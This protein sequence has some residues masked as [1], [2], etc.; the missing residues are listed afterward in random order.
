MTGF[1][2]LL[3]AH[4]RVWTD[5]TLPLRTRIDACQL[6]WD[7]VCRCGNA[8]TAETSEELVARVTAGGAI[9]KP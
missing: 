7:I 2:V 5:R 1:Y 6:M 9:P 3:R 8:S 4:D